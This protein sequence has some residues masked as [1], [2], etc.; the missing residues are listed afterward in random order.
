MNIFIL[1]TNVKKCAEYHCDKHVV[2]M[3]TESAQMLSTACRLNGINNGYKACYKFHPCSIWTRESLSNWLWLR[4]LVKHLNKE[5]RSRYHH[6]RNHKAYDVVKSLPEPKIKDIG[7]TKFAQ[8]MP[9]EYRSV[10]A[11]DAYRSYYM[12]DKRHIAQWRNGEPCWWK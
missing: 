3:I 11:V 6:S 7:L 1:D 12:G 9:D 8:A 4:E 5:W 10:D 2:K